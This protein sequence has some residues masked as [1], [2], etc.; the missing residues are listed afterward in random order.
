MTTLT[1]TE[2]YSPRLNDSGGRG[3]LQV[4]IA[5]GEAVTFQGSIDGKIFTTIEVFTVSSIK[6]IALC[7]RFKYT[8]TA[9]SSGGQQSTV[10]L[11][12]TRGI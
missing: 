2:V 4:T 9:G 6:E 10:M 1:A 11:A 5:D 12:E 3:I 8:I 7:P